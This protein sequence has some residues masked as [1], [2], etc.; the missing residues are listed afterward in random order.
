MVMSRAATVQ[1]Y[2]AGLPAE[3][4]AV[5]S[6]VRDGTVSAVGNYS[7][8]KRTGV[9][10]YYFRNGRLRATGRFAMGQI[11]GPWRWCRF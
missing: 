7:G 11:E 3:R 1:E 2:L 4:R 10:K 8:G 5:V 9:W 6:T